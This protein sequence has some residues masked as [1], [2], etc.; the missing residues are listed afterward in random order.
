M[1]RQTGES[2][3]LTG[4][5]RTE[6]PEERRMA[7]AARCA[8]ALVALTI[9]AAT[10]LPA[11][12]G[13]SVPLP[14]P[15][16]ASSAES[17]AAAVD[18]LIP[19]SNPLPPAVAPYA[20][21]VTKFPSPALPVRPAATTNPPMP[22]GGA[23]ASSAI[24]KA[25]RLPVLPRDPFSLLTGERTV[26]LSARLAPDGPDIPGGLVWRIFSDTADKDGN[27]P[28]VATV[29][30]GQASV[31]LKPGDYLVH[32]AY[33]L[34]S[35]TRELRVE[36]SDVDET[37]VLN[38][39]GLRLQAA[40]EDNA[41]LPSDLVTFEVYTDASNDTGRRRVVADAREGSILRLPAGT[42]HVISH[43]GS[44]NAVV[45][46]DIKVEPGKLT[47]ATIY[48]KA[49]KMTLKLVAASGGEAIADTA[50]TIIG[51]NGETVQESVGAFPSVVLVEG[52]YKVIARHGGRTFSREF[53]VEPGFNR[54][55]EVIAQSQPPQGL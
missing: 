16:P 31:R 8:A 49:A 45:R 28:L 38:A 12:A 39:G 21:V 19:Q 7:C 34:A 2:G 27:L 6:G 44:A 30:G 13:D 11:T 32:V 50:W 20:P 43:Y 4:N 10:I 18:A 15:R 42:Y 3:D 22:D 9:C 23:D 53:K 47:E 51:P 24:G 46:A 55:I 26:R 17:P 40:I 41:Y 36:S 29:K 25:A 14:R 1:S 48:Q 37:V 54:E 33:G 52:R 35:Q 5:A